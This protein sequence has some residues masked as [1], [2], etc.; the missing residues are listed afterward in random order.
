MKKIILLGA[1]RI[2]LAI[3]SMLVESGR[4]TVVV[5]DLSDTALKTMKQKGF[6][7]LKFDLASSDHVRLFKSF[8]A[9]VSA[10]P[11]S[12][13]LAVA[14]LALQAGCSYFDLTEDVACTK[15]IKLLAKK[16]TSGQVFMPQCGLAPGFISILA[17]SFLKEFDSL[18]N[19]Q[20]RVGA[21]PEFPSN[22][23]LYNLTWSTEGLINEYVNN[24]QAIKRG[25]LVEL[26]A[27][28]GYETFTLSGVSYEAFNTSGGLGSLCQSLVNDVSNLTYKTI[29]Y[30]GHCHLMKFLLLDLRLGESAAKR[31]NLINIL[32]SAIAVTEQDKI[33]IAV[34]ATGKIGH[35]LRQITQSYCIYHQEI[36]AEHY[37]AIQLATGASLCAVLDMVLSQDS[38]QGFVTQESILLTDFLK[39]S[40]AKVYRQAALAGH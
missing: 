28:E 17:A 16:S 7:V 32:E 24:C 5:A 15:A 11:F 26:E 22:Q 6:D 23:L 18:E 12:E 27:M 8:D 31:N 13:N 38:L 37:S 3:A 35:Q 10:L 33:V 21:L 29:R 40:F 14:E 2:G 19:L 36:N 39:S 30:P 1:G 20:L 25:K 34:V 9:V 4:F